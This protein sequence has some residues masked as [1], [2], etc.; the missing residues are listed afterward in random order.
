MPAFYPPGHLRQGSQL[1]NRT[2]CKFLGW[3]FSSFGYVAGTGGGLALDFG[4]GTHE[5]VVS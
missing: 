1:V 2:L 3:I 5:G 4:R